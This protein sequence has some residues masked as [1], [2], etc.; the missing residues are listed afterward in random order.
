M[1]LQIAQPAFMLV[2]LLR[3]LAS[4]ATVYLAAPRQAL[5]SLTLVALPAG[6][7][8]PLS[9]PAAA[10]A[11]AHLQQAHA[12]SSSCA[13]CGSVEGWPQPPPE[14]DPNECC[15]RGCAECVWTVYVERL[16]QYNAEMAA[17]GG[18]APP[19][20][21]FEALERKVAEKERRAEQNQPGP[22]TAAGAAAAAMPL[23]ASSMSA[24]AQ[25]ADSAACLPEPFWQGEPELMSGEQRALHVQAAA[26]LMA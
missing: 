26:A 23:Q 14:P 4:P 7:L 6:R 15:G 13:L 11:V 22:Q 25:P 16:Q 19:E 8:L 10:P 9:P 3:A 20:D 21:P 12:V 5:P 2:M 18:H 1:L 17:L 24:A